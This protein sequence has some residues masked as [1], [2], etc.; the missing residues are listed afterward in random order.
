MR[1][2]AA[3]S[4]SGEAAW[5]HKS[6]GNGLQAP[7]LLLAAVLAVFIAFLDVFCSI[8]L[9]FIAGMALAYFLDPVADRLER[10][11]LE[12]H[13]GDD[14]HPGRLR[15]RLRAGADDHHSGALHPGSDFAQ[16]LPGYITMLQQFIDAGAEFRWL[17]DWVEDQMGTIKDNLSA[18]LSDRARASSPA[19]FAQIWNSGKALRR[20]HLAVRGHA[21]RRLLSAAR[22]GPDGRQG[23]SVDPARLCRRCPPDRQRDGPGDR[24]FRPR[25]GLALPHPRHL[26]WRRPVVSS[27]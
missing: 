9:P 21:G 20:R 22:L 19:L 3:A 27:G 17:P 16:K 7:D 8:L 2:L 12:P 15:R 23:R 26:L 1:R 10:L 25:P 6:S 4:I 24:R 18:I 5:P 14:R 11:G 13:D